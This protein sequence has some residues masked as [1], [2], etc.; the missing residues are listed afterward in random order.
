MLLVDLPF[1]VRT[2]VFGSDDLHCH[3]ASG[4]LEPGQ[5]EGTDAERT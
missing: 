4:R 1:E 2:A 3:S 5:L